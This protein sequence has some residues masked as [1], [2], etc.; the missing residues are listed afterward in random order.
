MPE[1]KAPKKTPKLDMPRAIRPGEPGYG[2]KRKVVHVKN[3]AT[4]NVK[5]VRFGDAKLGLHVEN[6]KR[7]KNYC[8]RSAGIEGGGKD[9]TKANFWARRDWKCG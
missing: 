8:T 7:R 9:K 3:P 6:E 4:G 2:E 1:K 5:T